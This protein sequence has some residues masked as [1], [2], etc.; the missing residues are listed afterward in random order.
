MSVSRPPHRN[1]AGD[2]HPKMYLTPS[3]LLLYEFLLPLFQKIITVFAI[4]HCAELPR[5]KTLQ[6]SVGYMLSV[7]DLPFGDFLAAD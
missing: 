6:K 1:K 5:M 3:V 2:G 4:A 7:V